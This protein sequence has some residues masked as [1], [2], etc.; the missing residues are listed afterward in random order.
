MFKIIE[1]LTD[2]QV[3]LR[4]NSSQSLCLDPGTTSGKILNVELS[5]NPMVKKL[6]ERRVIALYPV[7]AAKEDFPESKTGTAVPKK[8]EKPKE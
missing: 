5:D 2:R 3:V 7:E 8:I 4:L 1:N 6:R